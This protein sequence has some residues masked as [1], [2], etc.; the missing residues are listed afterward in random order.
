[1]KKIILA[2]SIAFC[3]IALTSCGGFSKQQTAEQMNQPMNCAGLNMRNATWHYTNE[4]GQAINVTGTCKKG[5]KHGN[6][7]V[8]ANGQQIA[9]SKFGKDI[10]K[11]TTC[12][13]GGQ[14]TRIS[15]LGCMQANA[16]NAVPQGQAVSEAEAAA[17]ENEADED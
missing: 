11:K 4:F 3:A 17:D 8:Y 5:R 10:E 14:K 2:L 12:L 15:L 9:T 13:V 6:F 7:K 16:Q 1:M